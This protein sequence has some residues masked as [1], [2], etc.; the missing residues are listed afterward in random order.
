MKKW[1]V[2]VWALGLA[3]RA[4]GVMEE[5]PEYA[6]RDAEPEARREF[7]AP[8]E[9]EV[10]RQ[11]EAD[12]Q[13]SERKELARVLQLYHSGQLIEAIAL[14]EP[15]IEQ[16]PTEMAAWNALGQ[17]YLKINRRDDALRLWDRLRIIRPDFF[18]VYNWIGRAHMQCNE[19]QPAIAAY[20][21]SLQLNPQQDRDQTKLNL[22]RM[23]RWSGDLERAAALLRPLHEAFP[24]RAE[25]TREL[26]SAL[27]S[28]RE[29]AEALPL[30]TTLRA[31][32]P[33]N[34]LFQAKEAVALLHTGHAPAGVAQ[35]RAVLAADTGQSDALGV[36]ADYAQFF[37]GQPE[38][39]LPWLQRMITITDQPVRQR[40]LTLRYVN[41]YGRLNEAAPDRFPLERT[42]PLLQGLIE[43]EHYD[44]DVRLALAETLMMCHRY[45][46]A[47][48][49]LIWVLDNLNP[50]N[51]RAQRNLFEI[52]L[53][54]GRSVE[55]REHLDKMAAFNPRDPLQHSYL[56]RFYAAH[57]DYRRALKEADELEA[58]GR[59]GAVAVLLYHGLSSSD[60]GAVLPA[61]RLREQLQ[62]L[63]AAGYRFVT[64]DKLTNCL[65][66][67]A[68]DTGTT[69][70]DAP[71]E[72]VACITFDD[73]RRDTMR[74]GT[75]VAQELKMAFS[76][77]VPVGYIE[78]QHPFICTWPQ[79]R[80]YQKTGRWIFG[81]HT[82]HAHE[83]TA[84]DDQRRLGFALPNHLW[85]PASGRLENDAEYAERLE[86]E[87]AGC[88]DAIVRE[89]GHAAEC[90][91]FAYPF[92]D[93][94]Q[95]TRSNDR[96]APAKNLEHC[97]RAYAIGFIQTSSGYAISG[98]NPLLYQRMEPDRLDTGADVL[99]KVLES[100][101]VNM[102]RRLRAEFAALEGKRHLVLATL[103]A[104][105][106]DGYPVTSLRK[107]H[108]SVEKKLGRHIPLAEGD[109]DQ[110]ATNAVAPAPAQLTPRPGIAAP[111]PRAETSSVALPPPEPPAEPRR[112]AP[113]RSLNSLRD[114]RD[115][116]K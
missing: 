34:R 94:G 51:A 18:P 47:R 72:R 13:S 88:R 97:G 87:Y 112:V 23:L 15:M 89:L 102:A 103:R 46:A 4:A 42:L 31:A 107:L 68:Q 61:S 1:T 45:D 109:I 41:L 111:P 77:H 2:I 74:Y 54:Q 114:L 35:A 73:A 37:G 52:A 43:K 29:F 99:R 90:N 71:L 83:R 56:A 63:R 70:P 86:H 100:H 38:E 57:Q 104:L 64:A 95:L 75:P 82:Y 69:D 50:H 25:I 60:A 66:G 85:L 30:W 48:A 14:L 105:Q 36:L 12:V 115:P 80:E 9:H 65:T 55:A 101:P 32:E 28:N 92:G 40:Q 91:F 8:D 20:R 53:A 26:A 78:N 81:G 59:Q 3:A 113:E 6:R 98:D 5:Q 10:L 58:A 49:Q 22:A 19:L 62:T 24:Q 116:L 76:M 84:I 17:S 11:L 96:A 110:P 27:L 21:A 79:L 7:P 33:T 108:A 44:A 93:I 16:D 67:N 39:A 106:R